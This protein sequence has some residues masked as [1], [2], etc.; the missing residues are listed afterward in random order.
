MLTGPERTDTMTIK[1]VKNE[2]K[3]ER[4]NIFSKFDE[5]LNLALLRLDIDN[6]T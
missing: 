4:N 2:Q 5:F 1:A 3:T 6:I